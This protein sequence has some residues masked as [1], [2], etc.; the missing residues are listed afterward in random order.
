M[1]FALLNLLN[2]DLDTCLDAVATFGWFNPVPAAAMRMDY[3]ERTRR[4]CHSAC[5]G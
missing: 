2:Y 1:P 4:T 5:V 3:V